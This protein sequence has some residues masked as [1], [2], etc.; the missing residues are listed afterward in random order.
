MLLPQVPVI[1]CSKATV[2]LTVEPVSLSEVR[3]ATS[4][5]QGK[6]DVLLLLCCV[7]FAYEVAFAAA[8]LL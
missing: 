1:C 5:V 3:D 8:L 7:T 2:F 4:G 6:A